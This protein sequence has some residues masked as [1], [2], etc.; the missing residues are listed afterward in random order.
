MNPQNFHNYQRARRRH[1]QTTKGQRASCHVDQPTSGERDAGHSA[2][3]Q[4]VDSTDES[5]IVCQRR[6]GHDLKSLSLNE[7]RVGGE[8]ELQRES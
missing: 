7:V 2:A 3:Y 4:T 5:N 1:N 6:P 8:P